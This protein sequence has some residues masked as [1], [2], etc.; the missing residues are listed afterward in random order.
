MTAYVVID[1]DVADPAGFQQYVDGVG[2][3]IAQ[4]GARTVVMDV[5]AQT[6]EG[7]WNPPALVI[8]EFTSK[9]AA[10]EFWDSPEYQPYKELRRK[11]ADVKVVLAATD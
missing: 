9:A 11:Y 5:E 6:L 1:L 2:P 3:M 10:M 4:A 7:D 8:H